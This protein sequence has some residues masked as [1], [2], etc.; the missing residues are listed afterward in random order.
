MVGYITWSAL[1]ILVLGLLALLYNRKN[2]NSI[3][4]SQTVIVIAVTILIIVAVYSM[5]VRGM[6]KNQMSEEIE[7]F[8]AED[9]EVSNGKH[10]AP[11][12]VADEEEEAVGVETEEVDEVEEEVE[13]LT[14]EPTEL[15]AGN[16]TVDEHIGSGVYDVTFTGTG[17]FV[18][19]GKDGTLG[20]N[21]I[22]GSSGNAVEKYRAILLEEDTIDL[23]STGAIFTPVVSF[24]SKYEEQVIHSGKWVVGVGVEGGRYIAR[25]SDGTTGNFTVYGDGGQLKVNEIVGNTEYSVPNVTVELAIG[26]LINASGVNIKLIPTD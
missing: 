19:R 6:E 18:V 1:A 22:G 7:E 3:G 5:F 11:W 8:I 25:S 16:F 21:I 10:L 26:D 14:T 4:N 17:N 23:S 24:D 15:G 9:E 12:E 20:T 13:P 2:D